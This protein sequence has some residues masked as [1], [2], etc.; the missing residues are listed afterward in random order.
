MT[1][2]IPDVLN[3]QHIGNILANLADNRSALPPCCLSNLMADIQISSNKRD[4]T[5]YR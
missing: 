2:D 1:Q 4:C 5:N 3:W